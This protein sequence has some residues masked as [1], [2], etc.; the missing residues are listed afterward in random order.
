MSSMRAKPIRYLIALVLVLSALGF[1]G[2][3]LRKQNNWP[4]PKPFTLVS[5]TYR[6]GG[7]GRRVLESTSTMFA[8]N[9]SSWREIRVFAKTEKVEQSVAKD[10]NIYDIVNGKLEWASRA[11][12]VDEPEVPPSE[13]FKGF[14][15]TE[16]LFGLTAYVARAEFG[17]GQWGEFW[18]TQETLGIPLKTHISRQGGKFQEVTE[19]LSLTFGDIPDSMF[20]NLDLP[21]SFDRASILLKAA[22]RA[23]Q[24]EFVDQTRALIEQEKKR[25]EQ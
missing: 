21:V 12:P 3:R 1:A 25:K 17:P 18:N 5:A 9:C 14:V 24:Q 19:P 10:G 6:V 11:T 8:R 4:K 16:R 2:A 15:R 20:D 13:Y 23:G 7:D 22:E